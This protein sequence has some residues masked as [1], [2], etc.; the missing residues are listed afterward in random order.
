MQRA[1]LGWIHATEQLRLCMIGQ[2]W[3]T[4]DATGGTCERMEMQR[5]HQ[6]YQ[7]RP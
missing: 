4:D 5:L 6:I 7:Q 2:P 1:R 3:H